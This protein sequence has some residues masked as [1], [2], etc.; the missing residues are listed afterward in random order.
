MFVHYVHTQ[1]FYILYEYSFNAV[2][3]INKIRGVIV[4]KYIAFVVSKLK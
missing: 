1:C 4:N 2:S 3:F